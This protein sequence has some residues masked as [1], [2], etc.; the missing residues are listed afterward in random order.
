MLADRT[1]VETPPSLATFE[2]DRPRRGSVE[3]AG[4]PDASEPARKGR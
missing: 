4:R 3:S 2:G 1:R